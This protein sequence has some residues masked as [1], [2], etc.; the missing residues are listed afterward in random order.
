LEY[1]NKGQNNTLRIRKWFC[2]DYKYSPARQQAYS[3]GV[4]LDFAVL[5]AFGY[6]TKYSG[7]V[8]FVG[9]VRVFFVWRV[10]GVCKVYV[11]L[12]M[13]EKPT[14]I[15]SMMTTATSNVTIKPTVKLLAC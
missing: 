9:S 1:E 5:P 10:L 2:V 15:I 4:S 6:N 8:R 7:T 3:K 12:T 14:D 13:K 11:W